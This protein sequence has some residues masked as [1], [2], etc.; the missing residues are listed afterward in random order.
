MQAQRRM[1]NK[2]KILYD[3]NKEDP[4]TGKIDSQELNWN[5]KPIEKNQ[6]FWEQD[7]KKE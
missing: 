6:E 1:G 5:E 4:I 7:P 2:D 3:N